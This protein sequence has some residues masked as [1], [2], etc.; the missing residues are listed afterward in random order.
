MGA[1][2]RNIIGTYFSYNRPTNN[3]I[4]REY[5]V[6][7]GQLIARLNTGVSIPA[8]EM[9]IP[10]EFEAEFDFDDDPPLNPP[11]TGDIVDPPGEITP[12]PVVPPA[13]V[14]TPPE[15]EPLRR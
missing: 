14:A 2:L 5:L 15:P 8:T 7:K 4:G 6:E 9:F 3:G 10:E 13:P 12:L 11:S 1:T